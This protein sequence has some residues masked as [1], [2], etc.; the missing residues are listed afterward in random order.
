MGV[1]H[2]A[3][4]G[5]ALVSAQVVVGG[6]GLQQLAI[7]FVAVLKPA[8]RH[9]GGR[10]N[11]VGRVLR[12]R[13]IE[14]AVLT[15]QKTRRRKRLHLFAFADVEPLPDVDERRYRGIKRT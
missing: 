9:S 12:E 15:S 11:R 3:D 2:R 4:E 5:L 14:R 7:E 10:A 13:N 8:R 6:A 1:V